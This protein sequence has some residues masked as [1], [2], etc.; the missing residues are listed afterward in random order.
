METQKFVAILLGY[1]VGNKKDGEV[2][3]DVTLRA[4]ITAAISAG[5]FG[6]VGR[7]VDVE[8]KDRY[9]GKTTSVTVG[10]TTWKQPPLGESEEETGRLAAKAL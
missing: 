3:A 8:V 6:F 1:K 4:D 2:F 10:D 9:L 7:E 5:L